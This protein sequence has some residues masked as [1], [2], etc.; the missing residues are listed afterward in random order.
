MLSRK[1][2]DKSARIIFESENVRKMLFNDLFWGIRAH[3]WEEIVTFGW[4]MITLEGPQGIVDKSFKKSWQRPPPPFWQCQKGGRL[5]PLSGFFWRICPQC[6]EGPSKV[7]IHHQKVIISPQK[8]ALIPKNRSFNHISL[9]FSLTKM[10]YA[11]LSKNVESHIRAFMDHIR[12]D[13]RI[14]GWGGSI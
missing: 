2:F 1:F 3:F 14:R 12:Q 4:W 7:I 10:I 11:L 9:T 8:C 13:T 5:C 6:T